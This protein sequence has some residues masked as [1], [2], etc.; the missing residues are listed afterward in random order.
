MIVVSSDD[1]N[2]GLAAKLS[3]DSQYHH[4]QN[5][6]GRWFFCF[7]VHSHIFQGNEVVTL[8]AQT[9]FLSRF[10]LDGLIIRNNPLEF[11]DVK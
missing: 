7:N 2:H 11:F 3:S 8:L 10:K 5:G 4:P 9:C 6:L 1:V